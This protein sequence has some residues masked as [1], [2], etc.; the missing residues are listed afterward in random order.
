MVDA[1]TAVRARRR[2]SNKLIAAHEAARLKPFFLPDARVIAGDGTLIAGA[3]AI[4]DAFA[5]QF[6]E[7]G[8]IAYE[9][10]TSRVA[11]DASQRRAAEHGT[12][13]GRWRGRPALS[14]EYLAV[15]RKVTGQW[16]I[17]SELYV[18]LAEAPE[19][20]A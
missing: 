3:A 15:W 6:V 13:I 14:G 5:S 4:L 10:T 16:A 11:L 19:G 20:A 2:L 9:R 7:P 8:F 1:E 12:W 17:E 18:T